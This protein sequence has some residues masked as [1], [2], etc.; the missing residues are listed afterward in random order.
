MESELCETEVTKPGYATSEFWLTM[1]ATVAAGL[2]TVLV[3]GSPGHQIAAA[4]VAGLAA[5]G[6]TVSRSI[7]K[8]SAM[9]NEAFVKL[10]K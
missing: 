5:L 8:C 4:I 9:D 10:R 1:I 6:Y 7:V 2:T 3:E